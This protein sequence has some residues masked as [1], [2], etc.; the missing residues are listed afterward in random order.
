MHE[1]GC[2]G[3]ARQ[4]VGLGKEEALETAARFD[5]GRGRPESFRFE[6]LR[7]LEDIQA[8]WKRDVNHVDVPAPELVDHC[9]WGHWLSEAVFTRFQ[10]RVSP[11]CP[12]R[13]PKRQ[14]VAND[15]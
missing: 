11:A 4:G 15:A 7:H 3:V 5:E 6:D 14:R 13:G 9:Q 10:T 12:K 8:L 2:V 1:L